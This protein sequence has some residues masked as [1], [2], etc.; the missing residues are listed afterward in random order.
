MNMNGDSLLNLAQRGF[1]LLACATALLASGCSSSSKTASQN[2]GNF[3][4]TVFIGDSLTAGY[5][6]GSLLDTQQPH[7]YANLIAQQ[8]KFPLTLPLIAPPGAP[9]VMTLVSLGPPPV[10]GIM[11]PGQS[12]I[13]R[14]DYMVQATDLAVPGALVNDVLNT[15]PVAIPTTAEQQITQ[16]VIGF[17][18]LSDNI[19]RTQLGWAVA[20]NPTTIIVWIGNNDAL[21]ADETGM[22]ASMTPLATFTTEF[23][24]LM[25]N[26]SKQTHANLIVSNLPDVT[27]VPYLTPAL[28]VLEEACL[29]A[30]GSVTPACI[31]SM[32]QLLGI[33][34]A[35]TTYAGDLVNPTGLAEVSLILTGKQAPPITDSGF[36][37]AA[38]VVTVQQMV[39]SYNQVIQQQATAVGATLVDFHTV[40]AQTAASGVTANGYTGNFSYLGGMFGLDGVHPS[41]T[42]YGVV[43]NAFIDAM[44][45]S[46]HTTIPDVNLSTIAAQD[47]LWPPNLAKS[48]GVKSIAR[49]HISTQAGQSVAWMFPKRAGV[50]GA[51]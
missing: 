8:A 10:T 34:P 15:V 43:A 27:L 7:G 11:D 4:T 31:A 51:Q 22:P 41:N 36:L 45:A 47:P 30:Y 17:P 49:Q 28:Q 40:F 42:G 6:N 26:L 35:G 46:L 19:A 37:S 9:N 39:L 1:L 32:S 20:L 5:Q 50:A 33:Q 23:T 21:V 13:G 14:D 3:S 25:S 18:G 24:Q 12:T 2:A 38:E 48:L 16:L 29:G 44:N